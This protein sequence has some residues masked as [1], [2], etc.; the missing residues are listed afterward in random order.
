MKRRGKP[1]KF[2]KQRQKKRN[3]NEKNRKEQGRISEKMEK[4]KL[5]VGGEGNR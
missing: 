3:W 4:K 2:E 1:I 5:W